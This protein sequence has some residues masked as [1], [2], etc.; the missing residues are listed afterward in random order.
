MNNSEILRQLDSAMKAITVA[1]VSGGLLNTEKA[2]QFIR[3][4]EEATPVLTGARRMPMRA[5]TRDIDRIAFTGRVLTDPATAEADEEGS[6]PTLAQNQLSVEESMGSIGFKDQTL[7]D[8]IERENLE[9]TVLQLGGRQV[10]R[11][12]EE[13]FFNGDTTSGDSFLALID[14]W[15]KLAGNSVTGGDQ[16][17]VDAGTADFLESDVEAAFDAM[18]QAIPKKYIRDRSE[19]VIL[20]T[21]D[22]EDDYRDVLRA[23]NT[24][25][26][27]A[28]QTGDAPLRYKGFD[29]MYVPVLNSGEA[30]LTTLQNMVY[31]I[32]REVRVEPDRIPRQRQTDFIITVRADA[33]FED[34][35]AV[36]V[37]DGYTG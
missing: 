32:Y 14:G 30:M 29:V 17:A 20:V 11:D 18:I 21:W 15:V 4:A 3:E 1:D 37:A 27:D 31:G 24:D 19:W 35:N 28:A 16:A 5:P 2:D 8:N 10:G 7:E 6:K 9:D 25:L 12:L 36:V 33:H 34:E 26:G 13:L 23:R 22:M